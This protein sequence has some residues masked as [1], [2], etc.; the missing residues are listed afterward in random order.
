[1]NYDI[2]KS[3][4]TVQP[5]D[6]RELM[7][8]TTCLLLVSLKGSFKIMLEEER[9]IYCILV[10]VILSRWSSSEVITDNRQG[11]CRDSLELYLECSL[12]FFL[13]AFVVPVM[14]GGDGVMML[15]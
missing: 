11:S 14:G 10:S 6:L 2:M 9:Y 3:E 4:I 15:T 12:L 13:I 1:M 5:N 8:K 7:M